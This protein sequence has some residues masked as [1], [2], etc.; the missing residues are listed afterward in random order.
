MARYQKFLHVLSTHVKT[1][2]PLEVVELEYMTAETPQ[3][4]GRGQVGGATLA[5]LE[6]P[7]PFPKKKKIV[8]Q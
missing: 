1:T 7:Y 4:K 3:M 8:V 2:L 6:S 5:S